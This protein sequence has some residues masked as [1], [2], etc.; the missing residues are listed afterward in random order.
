MIQ[1]KAIKLF[2]AAC[3]RKERLYNLY[4]CISSLEEADKEKTGNVQE[5]SRRLL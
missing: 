1:I 2:A 3:N 5:S 4:V